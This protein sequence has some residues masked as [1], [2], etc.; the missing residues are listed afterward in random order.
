L[1]IALVGGNVIIGNSLVGGDINIGNNI[2]GGNIN[3]GTN[4]RDNSMYVG[5]TLMTT[6]VTYI[7]GGTTGG[8]ISEQIYHPEQLIL[9][10]IQIQVKQQY[11]EEQLEECT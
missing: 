1:V 3:I 11:M 7:Y 9:V 5:S 4:I 2:S 6:G 8:K 10:K